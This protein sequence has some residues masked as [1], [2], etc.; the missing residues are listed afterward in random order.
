MKVKDLL[1]VLK[2]NSCIIHFKTKYNGLEF[3][4]KYIHN[5][6]EYEKL[7]DDFLNITIDEIVEST[8]VN[9]A[10]IVVLK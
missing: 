4:T 2:L 3:T 5:Y 9:N 7:S 6:R 8:N 10:L 1:Q